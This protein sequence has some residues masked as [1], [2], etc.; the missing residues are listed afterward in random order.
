MGLFK[1]VIQWGSVKAVKERGNFERS[2]KGVLLVGHS[3]QSFNKIIERN[4][5]ERSFRAGT[6]KGVI[7]FVVEVKCLSAF[8]IKTMQSEVNL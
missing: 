1:V 8:R 2:L 3:R 4:Q 6:I 7:Y 5:S